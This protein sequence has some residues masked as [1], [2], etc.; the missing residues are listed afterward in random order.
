MIDKN[1]IITD[2]YKKTFHFIFPT[3][4]SRGIYRERTSFFIK[5]KSKEN[6]N[7][8]GI[9]ECAPLPLL[10]Q[11]N[12]NNYQDMLQRACSLYCH[13]GRIDYKAL[14]AYPSILFGLET[15]ER[16]FLRKGSTALSDTPF[17]KGKQPIKINGL[18]WMG[19]YNEMKKRI[20]EK[21][22]KGFSCI[23]LKI[24]AIDFDKEINLIKYIRELYDKNKLEIRVDANG[25]FDA[26]RALDKLNVLSKYDIHSIEQPIK[27]GQWKKMAMISKISPIDVAL[28]E[29]LIGIN[30]KKDKEELLD[31]IKPKYI[32][33]KP[34]LHGGFYGTKE[35]IE[36]AKQRGVKYWITSALES[37]VGLNAIAHL[38]AEVNN[39]TTDI[40]PQGLG[41]GL[42]YNDNI[43]MPLH[44][45]GEKL[46]YSKSL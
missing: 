2:I 32:V 22:N 43:D 46:W 6:N 18:V 27:Q 39:N 10:S 11:E 41:T 33:I 3:A 34:S 19:T 30:T 17:A 23:K 20:D 13:T 28:D 16:Q 25:A 40:I 42:L 14:R 24:G 38:C 4:T 29:E 12:P 8:I 9:G 21:I 7:Y 1:C 5:I 31:I 36:L 45:E 44:I 37:N 35:W 26:D 15:A